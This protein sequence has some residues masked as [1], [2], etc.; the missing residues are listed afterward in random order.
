M[1]AP[2][3]PRTAG[4]PQPVRGSRTVGRF[5]QGSRP[6]AGANAHPQTARTYLLRSYLYCHLCQRRMW[7]GTKK[8]VTYY[9]CKKNEKNHG[10]LPWYDQHPPHV[11]VREDLLL[12]PVARFFKQRI[13]GPARKILLEDALPDRQPDHDLEA[14][15][16][17]VQAELADLQRWGRGPVRG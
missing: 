11:T 2:A 12:S 3:H 7:G 9:H 15:R 4:H 16:N 13:F 6:E 1:V 14:R 8:T 10:R 17:A 5:R